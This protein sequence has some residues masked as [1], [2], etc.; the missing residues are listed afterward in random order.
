MC[1]FITKTKQ[2]GDYQMPQFKA[3]EQALKFAGED[4][5]NYIQQSLE[6]YVGKGYYTLEYASS[7][8]LGT[9]LMGN[10]GD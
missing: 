6:E 7:V 4:Y 10:D 1:Y 5:A 9:L 2:E 8:D 3:T